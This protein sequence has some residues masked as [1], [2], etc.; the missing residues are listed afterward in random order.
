MV[1]DDYYDGLIA[2]WYDDWLASRHDDVDYYTTFLKGFKGCVLELACGTGRILLP[3]ARQG[4]AIDGLDSSG[5]MLDRLQAKA[6]ALGLDSI[7]TFKQPM[8][9][10]TLPGKYDAIVITSGSFQLLIS[11][12]EVMACLKSIKGHLAEGGFLLMDV[13]VPWNSIRAGKVDSFAVTRDSKRED[14]S[15]CVVSERFEVDTARQVVNSVFRYETFKDNKLDKSMIG[16]FPLRWY[17]KDEICNLLKG[18]GFSQVELLTASP[19]YR[20]GS[21]FVIKAR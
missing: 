19:L 20:E 15:R 16:D 8:A 12:E 9:G 10:F 5:D 14:G 3:V 2:E 11:E 4:V 7:S 1:R 13:F 18:H 21:S 6:K 17:W